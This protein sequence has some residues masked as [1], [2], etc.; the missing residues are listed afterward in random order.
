M[1]RRSDRNRSDSDNHR[2]PGSAMRSSCPS[3]Q[4]DENLRRRMERAGDVLR[5][6][7]WRH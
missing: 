2:V 7:D 6:Q 5:R 1:K 3:R 4:M